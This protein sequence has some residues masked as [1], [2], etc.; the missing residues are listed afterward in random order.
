MATSDPA[1][2]DPPADWGIQPGY[3]DVWGSWKTPSDEAETLI[4]RAMGAQTDDPA[5]RPPESTPLRIV[6]PGDAGASSTTGPSWLTLEDGV[7]I[8]LANGLL[9][10][11]L[12]LGYHRI[13]S[14]AGRSDP[15]VEHLIVAPPRAHLD[16]AMRLW[17][18]TAQLYAARSRQSWGMGDLTDLG[19]LI[20]WAT[21][22]GAGMIGLNPLH[23]PAPVGPPAN[24]PYSP[25]TRRWRDPLYLDVSELLGEVDPATR[26]EAEAASRQLNAG[27]R[28]DRT[29]VWELKRTVLDA[30]WARG[31]NDP[32][33]DTFR[34]ERGDALTLWGTYC[35]LSE[36]HGASWHTWPEDLRHPHTPAVR[37]FASSS[38]AAERIAFWSWLQFLIEG[39][40]AAAGAQEVVVTDLAVGFAPDGF[41]AWEWQDH[42][43][44]GCRIGAPPDLLGPDGQDW[45]L[46]PFVPWKLRS[47]AYRPWAETL[48]ANLLH[49]R[50]LR[51]DHVMGLLRLL[52]IPPGLTAADGAYVQWHGTELLDIVAL[53]SA[54]AG[55]FVVG[56]DLGTVDPGIQDQLRR[57]G[58]LSTRL[59]WFEDP[60]PN[61]WP[62]QA[63]AAITTHDLPTVAGVWSGVDLADQRAAGVTVPANGDDD[64]R[65]RLRVAAHC[66]D[67][68]PVDHVVVASYRRLAE[69]PCMIV[70]AALDDLMGAEHRP[71]VPGTIDEH[72]NWRI[73]LPVPLDDLEATPLADRIVDALQR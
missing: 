21:E 25:S 13:E 70:T 3:H 66:D 60:P 58:L 38:A 6:H 48:R 55:A 68:A 5:E 43:A 49:A 17:G 14:D 57:R 69:S 1:A 50:G 59:L 16:D 62:Q 56:E 71:N 34:A 10:P 42:L 23:A 11:D 31:V 4:R 8:Q 63:M 9:P 54:R 41:D 19:V 53:E 35:A 40:F 46:P 29:A 67:A 47:Q 37:R 20:D 44:E 28:I 7:Q 33:F 51:V 26:V 65:H 15:Q 64:F 45:G 36:Q 24:S 2:A 61:E 32:A 30:R 72:P 73:P 18:I 22:R 39:Q 27:G 52:W 12:P